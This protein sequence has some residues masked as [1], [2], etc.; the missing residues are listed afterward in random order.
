MNNEAIDRL[1]DQ[2]SHFVFHGVRAGQITTT[3]QLKVELF[4][5]LQNAGL[6]VTDDVP[7]S[8]MMMGAIQLSEGYR[9][10]IEQ[11][12][13]EDQAFGLLLKCMDIDALRNR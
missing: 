10:M 6:K 4:K 1:M 3:T 9:N 13:T 2:I 11:G 12:F 8:S 5:Q 7:M